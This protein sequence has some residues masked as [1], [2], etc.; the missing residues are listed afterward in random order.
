MTIYGTVTIYGFTPAVV[1]STPDVKNLTDNNTHDT[2]HHSNVIIIV[3]QYVNNLS[4]AALDYMTDLT[5]VAN[6]IQMHRQTNR[7]TDRH[8]YTHN[9]VTVH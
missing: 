9:T 5:T 1:V 7:H 2:L 3:T 6:Q 8:T 4:P